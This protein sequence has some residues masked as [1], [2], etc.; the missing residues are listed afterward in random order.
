MKILYDH[1]A[2]SLQMYGGVSR[3]F[4][5]LAKNVSSLNLMTE[6]YSPVY[7]NRYLLN[8]YN[9]NSSG[10]CVNSSS[11]TAIKLVYGV[12]ELLKSII[13]RDRCDILHETYYA[14]S[15]RI[16]SKKKVITVFD[17]IP[18]VLS[19]K[20]GAP[21]LDPVKVRAIDRA[22]HVICI[23]RST[24][25]D[26]IRFYGVERKKTSV[27]YLGAFSSDATP[28]NNIIYRDPYILYVGKRSG[29]KN[30]Y[31]LVE[32]Y[33]RSSQLRNNACIVIFGGGELL[34]KEKK[35]LS[36][37]GILDKV[38]Y[39]HGDDSLLSAYYNNALM[40]VYPSLY[41]GFGL[42][43]LEA[44][45]LGVPVVCSNAGSIPEVVG[46]AG[47]YFAPTNYDQLRAVMEDVLNDSSLRNKMS[48]DGMKQSAKFSWF[49]TATETLTV[50][51]QL[52]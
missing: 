4:V 6:V 1:Q 46:D 28:N 13:V 44:M 51:E 26:L 18:E 19:S 49:K 38:I 50:Y 45:K 43:P 21:Q 17:L 52:L 27:V 40:F 8:D 37:Y 47:L 10:F 9:R 7:V 16:K 39:I 33:S 24:Q 5:E 35:L 41:E 31:A 36:H 25:N 11:P 29:Y 42:P 2:F 22:D 48:F 32:A 30:F 3:Y 12:N 14:C 20:Y 23:S 34:D 15:Q